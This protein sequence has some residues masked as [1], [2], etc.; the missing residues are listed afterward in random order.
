MKRGSVASIS[1][2]ENGI[3]EALQSVPETRLI[4][5]VP[6]LYETVA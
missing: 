3:R 2:L 1:Y 4:A 6:F 5:G